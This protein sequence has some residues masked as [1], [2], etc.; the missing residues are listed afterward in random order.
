MLGD[1]VKKIRKK[2]EKSLQTLANQVGVS[3]SLLSQIEGGKVN[4]S[5]N[6]LWSLADAL[7]VHVSTLLR[8]ERESKL[9]I[10]PA[11]VK[12]TSNGTKSYVLSPHIFS[13]LGD[14]EFVYT[15]YSI[16]GSSGRTSA[17]HDG[18]EYFLVLEGTIEVTIGAKNFTLRKDEGVHFPG[19][20]PHNM[21]NVGKKIARAIFVVVPSKWGTE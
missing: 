12:A 16:G 8:N 1:R 5:I 15:E 14:I 3:R 11:Q 20:I 10:E 13:D 7:G 2:Q 4:P 18:I 9:V 6:T 21:E 17:Q 19:R